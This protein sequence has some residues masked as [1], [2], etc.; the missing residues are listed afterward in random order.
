[1]RRLA[2][3]LVAG[4][5]G[6]GWPE[7]IDVRDI[8]AAGGSP[9]VERV[10]DLG[11]IV[12]PESGSLPKPDSDGLFVVGE[13][14][15]IEG[16]DFGKLPTILVGGRPAGVLARTGGG[17]IVTRVP[18]GV[19]PGKVAVEVSHPRGKSSKEIQVK[20]YGLVA[21]SDADRIYVLDV[22]KDD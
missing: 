8:S 15:L 21:Q 22:A 19:P 9:Q 16:D 12:M 17:G 7:V 1:M 11:Q 20:R 18:D 14:V 4:A 6:G 10:R 2:L 13:L 5:C 3:V